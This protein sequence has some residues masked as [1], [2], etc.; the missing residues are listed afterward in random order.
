LPDPRP[1]RRISRPPAKGES[2]R[3]SAQGE[4]DGGSWTIVARDR[5]AEERW[6]QLCAQLAGNCQRAYDQLVV[7]PKYQDG[8]RL[9]KLR[10]RKYE[11]LY[12]HEV[13]GGQRLW[14]RLDEER[15]AVIIEPWTAHPK[16][17]EA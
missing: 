4:P 16:E 5:S 7:D 8:R 12:Q 11:G 15:R 3:Q 17:T 9:I 2:Q 6:Q 13:G 10:G 14:Y 1:T